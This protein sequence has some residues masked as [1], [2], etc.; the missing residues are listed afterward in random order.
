MFNGLGELPGEYTIQVKS[1]T[2]P[3][4]NPPR[5]LPV[6]LRKVVKTELE[7]MVDKEIIAPVTESTPWVSSMVVA[8]KKDGRL[9][10][11]L[12]PKHLN[13]VIMRSHYPL[14]TIEEVT[15][16]LTNAKV[17]SVLDAK[18]GFWQVRLSEASSYLTMFN[19]PLGGIDGKG[20]PL[21]LVVPQRCGNKR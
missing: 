14:P 20:C 18:T 4:V 21:A 10:I 19:T 9:R 8:Q 16:R 6:S 5:R 2:V 3:V 17:F 12:D 7:M 15:T 1:D 13:K 11:C